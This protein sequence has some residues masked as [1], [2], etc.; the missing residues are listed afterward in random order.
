MRSVSCLSICAAAAALGMS[1]PVIGH[2]AKDS[3]STTPTRVGGDLAVTAKVVDGQWRSG[4][5]LIEE[6]LPE[7]YADPTPPGAIDIKTYPSLRRAEVTG[8]AR[9]QWGMNGGFWPLFQ[10]IQRREIAMT[11][12]VEMDLTGWDGTMGDQPDQWTMSFL[13]RTADLGPTGT[14]ESDSRV[15]VVDTAPQTYVS[16]GLQGPYGM[17]TA[18]RGMKALDA[19]LSESSEWERAGEPRV[20]YYNGPYIANRIK[21]AEVQVPVTPTNPNVALAML[22]PES[23]ATSSQ[24]IVSTAMDAGSFTTLLAA[25]E[26][27][28]LVDALSGEGPLTVFAPTD[29]AF[30]AVPDAVIGALLN[31]ANKAA[32]VEVLTY[33]VVPGRVSAVDAIRAEGAGTL[34][35]ADVR[36]SIDAGR[37]RVNDATIVKNDIDAGNG[38]IHVIDTVMLP[39]GLSLAPPRLT[40]RAQIER[41]VELGAPLFNDGQITACAAI[42]EVTVEALRARNDLPLS[43]AARRALDDVSGIQWDAHSA[44]E[45]AWDVRRALDL[46]YAELVERE[47]TVM[48][49]A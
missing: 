31:P 11:S 45:Y 43:P 39:P 20:L 38:V 24:T 22:E 3:V 37:L 8:E 23:S 12:P 17:D 4:T 10:H 25:A 18:T 13:Y 21:W 36:F 30:E 49:G 16:A 34:Q 9:G 5:A 1:G 41:A 32:L 29:E 47:A 14:D 44:R 28:G 48:S 19:W 35:G 15:V 7:G 46:V 2:V 33:H 40:G 6:A 26:A 27:A 42:Y